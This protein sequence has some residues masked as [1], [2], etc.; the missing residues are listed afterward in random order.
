[1]RRFLCLVN[2]DSDS[3]QYCSDEELR[4]MLNRAPGEAR[5]MLIRDV[6]LKCD[7]DGNEYLKEDEMRTFAMLT[8]FEGTNSEWSEEF[9]TLCLE[10]NVD[11]AMGI[12]WDNFLDLVNDESESGQFCSNEELREMLGSLALFPP[13]SSKPAPPKS[14]A[15]VVTQPAPPKSGGSKPTKQEPLAKKEAPANQRQEVPAPKE[16]AEN[17]TPW[18][19]MLMKAQEVDPAPVKKKFH[20]VQTDRL[21]AALASK[22]TPSVIAPSQLDASRHG[23]TARDTGTA[24]VGGG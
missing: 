4:D 2:D 10:Q 18:L 7:A 23:G 1:V 11:K 9:K 12:P 17:A 6:F 15:A 3:G 13:E 19:P 5:E 22:P 14:A 21:K 16:K 24:R 20:D 8:G